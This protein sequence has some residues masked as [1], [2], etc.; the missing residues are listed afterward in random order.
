M[1]SLI[2]ELQHEALNSNIRIGDLLRKAKAIAIKLD[3]PALRDWVDFELN[4]YSGT[5]VPDYRIIVGRVKA[6][7]Q[8]R[9]WI[10]VIFPNNDLEQTVATQ[11]ISDRIATLEDLTKNSGDKVLTTSLNSE[12]KRLLMDL[13][14]YEDDFTVTIHRSA[15]EGITTVRLQVEQIQLVAIIA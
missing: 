7:N 2:E 5:D 11:Y 12:A 3:L 1:A 13:F 9:G 14:E 15:I 10:P 4:G 6:H 8:F